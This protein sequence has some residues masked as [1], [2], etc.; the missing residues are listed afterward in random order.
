MEDLI[1]KFID[2][3]SQHE[4]KNYQKEKT[5]WERFWQKQKNYFLKY[6]E[7]FEIRDQ[8]DY[9]C[10]LAL[11]QHY[12][13]IIG[14]L[15]KKRFL[16]CGCGSGFE[17][18]LISKDGGNATIIDYSKYSIDYA[19]IVARRTGQNNKINFILKDF[20]QYKSI[21]KY[22]VVWNCGVI[23]H[24]FE[25]QSI[26]LIKKM[27]E[28]TK[29]GGKVI[30]TVPNL[31]SPQSLYWS[32]FSSKGNEKYLSHRKLKMIM[33]KAGLVNVKIVNFHYWL[34]SYIPYKWAI[35][36]SQNKLINNQKLFVWL[37]TGVGN[38]N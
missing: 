4:N 5:Y 11:H 20:T 34:P 38:V 9:N 25:Q 16:E 17:S 13:S 18:C 32:I 21:R 8:W 30:V 6:G 14:Y 31:L 19:R 12:K 3:I 27:K 1:T 15:R 37:F 36:V 2:L 24:Y 22:D 26:S 23:E 33:E 29:S 10:N 7:I 35:K 28:L